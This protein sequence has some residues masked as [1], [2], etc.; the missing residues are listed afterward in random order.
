MAKAT[1]DLAALT[2]RNREARAE[3]NE[4]LNALV[5]AKQ[6][7]RRG[8][9]DTPA[10]TGV[11]SRL[12]RVEDRDHPGDSPCLAGRDAVTGLPN[13][14][15]LLDRLAH[16]LAL[17]ARHGHRLALLFLDINHFKTINDSLGHDAGDRVLRQVGASLVASVRDADT[18]CRYGGDEFLILLPEV[19]RAEDAMAI[20]DKIVA[21]LDIPCVMNGQPLHL[22]ASIGIS[23]FP[24]DGEDANTLI[25]KA[26]AAMYGAKR[27]GVGRLL[28][29]GSLGPSVSGIELSSLTARSRP[30]LSPDAIL[31]ERVAH[32]QALCEANE[33]LV[34]AALNAQ[35][36]YATAELAHRRQKEYMAVVVHELRNPLTPIRVAA[37]ML[38][39]SRAEEIPR[40]QETIERQVMHMSRLVSDLLDM[41]RSDTGKLRLVV[42]DLNLVNTLDDSV[43]SCQP[44]MD[45]RR[46]VLDV[47]RPGHSLP[48]RGDPV[49]LA[50]VLTNLL[51]NASKYTPERGRI[52]LVVT[53]AG[54]D[55][56][57]RVTDSGI[58]MSGASLHDVFEPFVQDVRAAVFNTEGLGIGLTVVRELVEAHGGRVV[59]SSAG[60]HLGS[61]FTVTLPIA[62]P[63]VPA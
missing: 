24:D 45:A 10:R 26:D 30:M 56:V 46:Q 2:A 29:D 23:L 62:G 47:Q 34:L 49:R 20:A 57:I 44:A 37:S 5:D 8:S 61:E 4:L 48:M 55:I 43:A 40:M 13:R 38:G 18:V 16:A 9:D 12:P 22:T 59:A 17:A 42:R 60:E 25:D 53:E 27:E 7:L 31:A 54:K 39:N 50:Q 51:D 1:R 19:A 52:E 36:L 63:P 41:S 3:L 35:T 21:C 15:L 11:E 14:G 32:N 58:G 28:F 33:Q 6:R